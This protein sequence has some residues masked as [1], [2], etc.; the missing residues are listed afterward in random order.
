MLELLLFLEAFLI[1]FVL[2]GVILSFSIGRSLLDIPNDRSSHSIPKPRLGGIAITVSFYVSV[3][4]FLLIGLRPAVPTSVFAGLLAGGCLI[5]MVGLVD[6]MRGLDARLK[7]IAQF[8]AAATVIASGVVLREFRIPL[9]GS[10][11]LGSLAAPVTA[12][13]IVAIINFYNFIDGIDG[14]AAGIGLIASGFLY[15]TGIMVGQAGLAGI[16]AIMAGSCLGFLRYNFPPARIFMGDMGSTFIGYTFAVFAL[17][18]DWVGVPAFLTIL[19]LAAVLADAVLTLLRR[20]AKRQRILSPHRTHYYQRLTDLGLS[21]KQVTLLEYL[22]AVLLGVSAIFTFG[23]ERVFIT[24]LSV[25]WV[26]FFLFALVKIRS[27]ERGGRLLWEG[28]SFTVA[29]A[30]LVFIAA[31][32]VL[33]YYLRLNFKFPQPETASMLISLPIVVIVRTAVFSYYGLYRG[34]WRYTNFDDLVRIVKAVSLSSLIM[35]ISFTFLFRFRAFPRSVFIIDWF[36]LTVFLTGS[37]VATRWFHDLPSREEL[38]GRKV[39]VAGTGHGAEALLHEIRKYGGMIPVGYLDDRLEMIGRT[40]HGLRVYGPISDIGRI[41]RHKGVDD[42]I[43]L[44]S[45]LE[46]LPRGCLEDLKGAGIALLVISDPSELSRVLAVGSDETPCAGGRVL[47][48]GN[49]E[50]VEHAGSVFRGAGELVVITDECRVLERGSGRFGVSH[51]GS[52]SYLGVIGDRLALRDVLE[53]HRPEFIFINF[54]FCSISPANALEAYLMTVFRPFERIVSEAVRIDGTRIIAVSR[55]PDQ[56]A[57]SIGR[58]AGVC[59]LMIRDACRLD[60]ARLSVLRLRGRQSSG[61]LAGALVDLVRAEGGVFRAGFG[62]ET[63][64]VERVA[65]QPPPPDFRSLVMELD[66]S[67]DKGDHSKLEELLHR[68]ETGYVVEEHGS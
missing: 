15:L 2:T 16:Y 49:G 48:A 55:T 54:S 65:T 13:W 19:L 12:F 22:V 3:T 18:G 24:L 43:V 25:I 61:F 31:S 38:A 20:I 28:R 56:E 23:E 59:E 4:T 39:M 63:A 7:L 5:A 26:G 46:R 66:R 64:S 33:S 32:Y 29:I 67:L 41:A 8:A 53:R 62:P 68:M 17:I 60:P 58:A 6:D 42:V 37:R 30:D 9:V 44:N 34:V 14:L 35:V 50:L 10:L 57:G 21:H 36:I 52:K 11:E 45:L 51:P 40:I 27:M 47:V 1:S